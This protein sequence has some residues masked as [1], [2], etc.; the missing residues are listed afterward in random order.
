MGIEVSSDEAINSTIYSSNSD[1]FNRPL[2]AR[3]VGA[4]VKPIDTDTQLV[5]RLCYFKDC[6]L[7]AL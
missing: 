3:P 4:T 7:K 1:T 5:L 2:S 6:F